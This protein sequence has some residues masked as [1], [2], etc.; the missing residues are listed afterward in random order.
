M[1]Y[2]PLFALAVALIPIGLLFA[3]VVSRQQDVAILTVEIKKSGEETDPA[4]IQQ[5][6]NLRSRDAGASLIELYDKTFSSIYMRREVIKA[7]GQL[8]GVADAEQ[9]AFQ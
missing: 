7:L 4:L 8:D 5:L 1:K 6:G 2:R 3:S 9:P